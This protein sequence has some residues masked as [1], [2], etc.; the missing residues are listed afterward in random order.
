MFIKERITKVGNVNLSSCNVAIVEDDQLVRAALIDDLKELGIHNIVE[1]ENGQDGLDL[2]ADSD[3]STDLIIC[4]LSMPKM[5]GFEF[6]SRLRANDS[7]EIASIPVLVLTGHIELENVQ[8]AVS[9]GIH[10][11]LRKP[12]KI[13]VLEQKLIRS[14]SAPPINSGRLSR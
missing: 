7:D 3:G 10:G 12:V 2:V 13:G 5:D 4:D 8:K 11:Y 14:Q 9:L 6:V 1:A